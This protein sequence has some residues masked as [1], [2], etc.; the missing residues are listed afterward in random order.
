[1]Y[2]DLPEN[3]AYLSAIAE[4]SFPTTHRSQ[5]DEAHTPTA[6]R[7]EGGG[8]GGGDTTT[9]FII[10]SFPLL[11]HPITQSLLLPPPSTPPTP[12]P[13]PNPSLNPT[14][15]HTTKNKR[16]PILLGA[17][18]T[19]D[20]DRGA[21]TGEVSPLLLRQLG[22]TIVEIGHAERRAVPFGESEGWIARK[23]RA[24]V[25]NGML[26][27]VCVG[28]K[29]HSGGGGGGDG[30]R[31]GG[32]GGGDGGADIDIETAVH[33]CTGQVLSAVDAVLDECTGQPGGTPHPHPGIVFA[34]EPVW[35]IGA[36]A[37]A[38]AGHVLGVVAALREVVRQRAPR[39]KGAV[40]FLYGGSAGPGTWQTLRSGCDGLFLGRFAHRVDNLV[41]VWREVDES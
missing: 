12:S 17:Q 5:N 41:Q 38:S 39:F 31:E 15:H 36:S 2:F 25:R 27:L 29:G 4:T 13:S 37:P 3:L 18:N 28:E 21:H 23:V 14:D 6:G 26:P 32:G 30:G 40:R 9:L 11:A 16:P 19:H 1:M 24:V 35:A 22:V 33:E 7:G 10:P 34:Y 20:A 8:G